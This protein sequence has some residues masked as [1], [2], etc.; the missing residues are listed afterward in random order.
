MAEVVATLGWP[1]QTAYSRLYAA[2]REVEEAAMRL[3]AFPTR[4][5]RAQ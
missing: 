4:D 5:P 3:R 2:R 1:L